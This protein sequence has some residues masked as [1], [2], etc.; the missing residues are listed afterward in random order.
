[1]VNR[2]Q[3][4]KGAAMVGTGAL[5]LRTRAW[6]FDQSP[7]NITKYAVTLPGLGPGGANN[8]GNY[9]SVLT[10]I[11]GSSYQIVAKQFTQQVHP[12]LPPTTFFGYADATTLDSRYLGGVI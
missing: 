3:F 11:L 5:L 4:V 9:I 7:T 6:P 10:P 2:R 12:N 1:M 8:I